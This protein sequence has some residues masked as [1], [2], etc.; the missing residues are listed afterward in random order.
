MTDHHPL[1]TYIIHLLRDKPDRSSA[2]KEARRLGVRLDYAEYYW[3]VM[4]NRG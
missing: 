1:T 4:A 3:R 2:G